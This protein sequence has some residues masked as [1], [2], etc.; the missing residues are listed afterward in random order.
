VVIYL[1]VEHAVITAIGRHEW[2]ISRWA[3]ILNGKPRAREGESAYPCHYAMVGTSMPLRVVKRADSCCRSFRG[4]IDSPGDA[5]HRQVT[6]PGR[7]ACGCAPPSADE[8]PSP[9]G[10]RAAM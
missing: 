5:T 4:Y 1:T 3:R 7:L 10:M 9:A 8:V 6:V 2:L